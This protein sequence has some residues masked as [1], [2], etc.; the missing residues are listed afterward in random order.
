MPDTDVVEFDLFQYL[1]FPKRC[2]G[3]TDDLEAKEKALIGF[4]ESDLAKHKLSLSVA[5][6]GLT[7]AL[8]NLF[9]QLTGLPPQ[10]ITYSEAWEHI[11]DQITPIKNKG[12]LLNEQISTSKNIRELL[13]QEGPIPTQYYQYHNPNV[14]S[15]KN[16]PLCNEMQARKKF[17][18]AVQNLC[19]NQP[20]T[21][22]LHFDSFIS[23]LCVAL[24]A[25]IAH[26]YSQHK[27]EYPIYEPGTTNVDYTQTMDH[28]KRLK[29]KLNTLLCRSSL[30]E[31]TII[32]IMSIWDNAAFRNYKIPATQRLHLARSVKLPEEELVG[33]ITQMNID[34]CENQHLIT[35]DIAA[36]YIFPDG[37]ITTAGY[38]RIL[39][40]LKPS[41]IAFFSNYELEKD[42]EK[43]PVF[44]TLFESIEHSTTQLSEGFP[45]IFDLDRNDP[46]YEF[47]HTLLK[48]QDLKTAEDL[49]IIATK[50]LKQILQTHII[51]Q[52]IEYR[53]Q[54]SNEAKKISEISEE[55]YDIAHQLVFYTA[56]NISRIALDEKTKDNLYGSSDRPFV[57]RERSNSSVPLYL[58][59]WLD[60]RLQHASNDKTRM[61]LLQ[62][63]LRVHQL[64]DN[65]VLSKAGRDNL[66]SLGL[67]L[68]LQPSSGGFFLD[69]GC[70][71]DLFSHKTPVNAKFAA[72][73]EHLWR[74]M[75]AQTITEFS[76]IPIERSPVSFVPGTRS[77]GSIILGEFLAKSS[78][79]IPVHFGLGD[80]YN[81]TSSLHNL[82]VELSKKTFFQERGGDFYTALTEAYKKEAS[83]LVTNTLEKF[84]RSDRNWLA[85][86]FNTFPAEVVLKAC[87]VLTNTYSKIYSKIP[88]YAREAESPDIKKFREKLNHILPI[89]HILMSPATSSFTFSRDSLE[90]WTKAT[91]HKEFY[92]TMQHVINQVRNRMSK[93]LGLDTDILLPLNVLVPAGLKHFDNKNAGFFSAICSPIATY[94]AGR[95]SIEP[96]F[97]NI[98]PDPCF[99]N[100]LRILLHLPDFLF[101]N[102]THEGIHPHIYRLYITRCNM[103]VETS[104]PRSNS[105]TYLSSR[106]MHEML[107]LDYLLS[108]T[109]GQYPIRQGSDIKSASPDKTNSEGL[110]FLSQI[111]SMFTY[112]K[113]SSRSKKML[114]SESL[115]ALLTPKLA[116][117][118]TGAI[119]PLSPEA[120]IHQK[121]N[122]GTW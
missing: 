72:L 29:T 56:T 33:L 4:L 48:K 112:N 86:M 118:I 67:H 104:Y 76:V 34:A 79:A 89:I 53:T 49:T 66:A 94:V 51:P 96:F 44:S 2:K 52:L 115:E 38:E 113:P 43:D 68:P 39:E 6:T 92:R 80:E 103:R 65:I 20:Y 28:R 8:T 47:L 55:N 42:L 116:L 9:G 108:T 120:T 60:D 16:K 98:Q 99:Q 13:N 77:V 83:I 50:N 19:R 30:S 15:A 23:P 63:I 7:K 10:Y 64:T 25:D 102:N 71:L 74:K 73:P 85:F 105:Q 107:T 17:R 58:Y 57:F 22:P 46:N 35:D 11:I 27:G 21:E 5:Q 100:L 69:D 88:E 32:K 1:S 109:T 121:Q 84:S 54:W 95:L 24:A 41:N 14:A 26:I 70:N 114:T 75:T 37:I 106:V 59:E 87:K 117:D 62:A 18:T 3:I 93:Y 97:Q 101:K 40:H 122:P 78:I 61:E 81:A 91:E 82:T 90:Y 119:D 12:V 45:E 111:F 31:E 36:P 110:P